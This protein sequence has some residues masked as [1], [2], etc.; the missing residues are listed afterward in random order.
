MTDTDAREEASKPFR[1]LAIDGGGSKGMFAVGALIELEEQL[2]QPCREVF[3]LVYGTSVGAIIAGLIAT[4]RSAREIYR[5]FLKEIPGIMGQRKAH[6]RSRVLRRV[7]NEMF[8]RQRF[9]DVDD[10]MLG[11]VVTRMD[12]ARPMI[13]KTTREQA[14]KGKPSFVP[15]WGATLAD[16]I[17]ASCAARPYFDVALVPTDDGDIPSIDGGFVANNPCLHALIEAIH[18]LRQPPDQVTAL[19][20]GVGSYP[21]RR[22]SGIGKL[23]KRWWPTQLLETILDANGA[24]TERLID[25]LFKEDVRIS[26]VNRAYSEPRYETSFLESDPDKLKFMARLGRTEVREHASE[27][28]AKLERPLA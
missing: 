12:E 16:A 11:I 20:V 19:S 24:D 2:D 1:V 23:V 27:I 28:C 14:I 17:V 10:V 13:Y 26:R 15:G 22:P 6:Q 7:A 25:L 9:A 3:D 5:W 8:G 4:G 18:L 21:E